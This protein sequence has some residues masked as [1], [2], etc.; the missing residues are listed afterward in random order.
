MNEKVGRPLTLKELS[1][2]SGGKRKSNRKY[3]AGTI[4]SRFSGAF[5]FRE[6]KYAVSKI[7]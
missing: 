1:I 4:F 6:V 7:K 3:G 2:V 5:A